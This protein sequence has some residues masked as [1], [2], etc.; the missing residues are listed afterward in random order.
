MGNNNLRTY[1]FCIIIPTKNRTVDLIQTLES[2][3]ISSIKPN[4]IVIVDDGE[5]EETRK[6][7]KELLISNPE[8]KFVI[9]R[10]KSTGLTMARNIGI[11]NKGDAEIIFFLDDDV[12]LELDYIEKILETFERYPE[13]HGCQGF[14]SNTVT[15]SKGIRLLIG[16]MAFFLPI[17]RS[18]FTPSV[19]KTIVGKYPLF[20]P[21]KRRIRTCQWLTG[22]NMAYRAEIFE[23]FKF[24]ENLI[25][26]SFYEDF[27]FSYGL[28]KKGFKL[29]I[30]FDAQLIHKSIHR[31][32]TNYKMPKEFLTL[33]D[34][35]YKF[36]E[37][38]KHIS[39]RK[40]AYLICR[41]HTLNLFILYCIDSF[42]RH[43]PDLFKYGLKS[44]HYIKLYEKDI[45]NGNL[46]S[47][48]T[49]I[50]K[51]ELK[52]YGL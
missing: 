12:I 2:V 30:N 20:I 8:I 44:Y 37:I 32:S 19:T 28:L 6:G 31:S 9:F 38:Y 35:G 13:I 3:C 11:E 48:N 33:M 43:R 26:F 25:L 27:D 21:N 40:M 1:K 50:K 52:N 36:Y 22:C 46:I 17:Q 24:D 34:M 5:I 49:M 7:I 45:A 23:N 4:R 41:Y 29:A 47:L 15:M 14:I 10:A 42:I 39:N 18:F 16:L 51:I